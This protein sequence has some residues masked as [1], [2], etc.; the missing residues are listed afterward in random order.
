M[1]KGAGWKEGAPCAAAATIRLWDLPPPSRGRE[2]PCSLPTS[3]APDPHAYSLMHP[4]HL[5]PGTPVLSLL[6]KAASRTMTYHAQPRRPLLC[7]NVLY[8]CLRARS[9]DISTHLALANLQLNTGGSSD[10][11]C[12]HPHAPAT[13]SAQPNM[14]PSQSNF[15]NP[16]RGLNMSSLD[17]QKSA[18]QG[19]QHKMTV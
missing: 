18:E 6:P 13:S 7:K 12:R 9:H 4:P 3:A 16:V 2:P 5:L 10:W 11:K 14:P 15:L 8:Q 19:W 1:E 17:G